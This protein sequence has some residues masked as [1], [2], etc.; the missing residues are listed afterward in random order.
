M[1][2]QKPYLFNACAL[3]FVL[4][5]LVE[6]TEAFNGIK[7]GANING[8]VG[9]S[10]ILM[11]GVWAGLGKSKIIGFIFGVFVYVLILFFSSFIY[12]YFK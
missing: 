6:I 8:G 10:G 9:A 7:P 12:S 5:I 11:L 2:I 3:M 1:K 4:I